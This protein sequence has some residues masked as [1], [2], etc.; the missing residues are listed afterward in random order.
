MVLRNLINNWMKRRGAN[1]CQINLRIGIHVQFANQSTTGKIFSSQ[2]E[3]ISGYV[4][5]V[6]KEKEGISVH[7]KNV[8]KEIGTYSIQGALSFIRETKKWAEKVI[9]TMRKITSY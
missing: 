4:K 8:A 6:D 3:G 9:A 7:V 5:N 1:S 2:K